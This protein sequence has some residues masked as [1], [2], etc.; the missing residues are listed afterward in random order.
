MSKYMV[1]LDFTPNEITKEILVRYI[2][3]TGDHVLLPSL[4][5]NVA[6]DAMTELAKAIRDCYGPIDGIKA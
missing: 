5:H 2:D 3:S 6:L 4:N 1:K